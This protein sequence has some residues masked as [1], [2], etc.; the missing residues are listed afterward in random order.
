VPFEEE[1]P[2]DIAER[3]DREIGYYQWVPIV[4][5]LMTALF[6]VPQFIWRTFSWQSGINIDEL[7]KKAKQVK[8]EKGKDKKA[9]L[10]ELADEVENALGASPPPR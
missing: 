9:A 10:V 3:G 6:Y 8:N 7:V 2:D 4:L 5:G 1:L